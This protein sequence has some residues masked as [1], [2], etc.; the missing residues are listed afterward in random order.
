MS[1]IKYIEVNGARLVYEHRAGHGHRGPLV[2][3]HGYALRGTGP[4]CEDL[5]EQLPRFMGTA[6]S[7][8][9]LCSN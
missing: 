3:M 4:A 6:N 8:S 9:A 1:E 5:F 7:P 2:F